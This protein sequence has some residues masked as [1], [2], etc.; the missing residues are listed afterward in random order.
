MA[1]LEAPDET[2]RAFL[3]RGFTADELNRFHHGV[4]AP[5]LA[6]DQVERG[7]LIATLEAYFAAGCSTQ[8]TAT[9]L[10]MHRNSV[11]YR[12]RRIEEVARV[13]L[14]DPTTRLLLELALLAGRLARADRLPR[15]SPLELTA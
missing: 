5:L 6:F 1:A 14:G 7:E 2:L 9:R 12:V 13:D 8:G 10:K 15:P 3:S 11:L 4:L